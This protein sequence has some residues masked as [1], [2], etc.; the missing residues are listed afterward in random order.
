MSE[1]VARGFLRALFH[2]AQSLLRYAPE[3]EAV[4][5]AVS[6]LRSASDA[7]TSGQPEVAITVGEDALFLGSQMLPHASIEFHGMRRDLQQR[8]DRGFLASQYD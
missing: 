5:S 8:I 4:K 7:L 1:L 3:H 6:A 2:A